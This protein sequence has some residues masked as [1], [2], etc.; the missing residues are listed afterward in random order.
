MRESSKEEPVA[1]ANDEAKRVNFD[2]KLFVGEQYISEGQFTY[3][4][5][6]KI[7]RQC[8]CS[9]IF[10]DE[11][12]EIPDLPGQILVIQA[13]ELESKTDAMHS[14]LRRVADFSI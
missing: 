5:L 7:T 1:A 4:S 3:S 8:K 6:E 14:C 2:F 11:R 10:F 12:T 13:E 9:D